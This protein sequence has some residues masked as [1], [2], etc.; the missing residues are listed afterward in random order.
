MKWAI[1][2][3]IMTCKDAIEKIGCTLLPDEKRVYRATIEFLEELKA[4][5]ETG[6]TPEQVKE[7]AEKHRSEF[8]PIAQYSDR[9]KPYPEI[10]PEDGQEVLVQMRD[11]H[12]TG[13]TYDDDNP[14]GFFDDHGEWIIG[15]DVVAWRSMPERYKGENEK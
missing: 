8:T 12:I 3:I 1:E 6:Y 14:A 11:W 15:D 10:E 13:G 9:W 2:E 7:L 5:R 4:Y